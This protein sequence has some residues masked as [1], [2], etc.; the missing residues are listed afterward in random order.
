MNLLKELA[1]V[2]VVVV[3]RAPRL[4]EPARLADTLARRTLRLVEITLTVE[5]ALEAISAIAAS[6]GS[7]AVVGAGTVLDADGARAAIAHGARFLVTPAG[8]DNVLAAGLDAGI[9]VMVGALTPTE[10]LTAW[11]GGASAVKVFPAGIGGP[12]YLRELSGPLP[13]IP[14]VPSGGVGA[15]DAAAFLDAGAAAVSCGSSA[16]PVRA[17]M[18]GDWAEIDGSAAKL[19]RAVSA[20]RAPAS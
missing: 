11:R 6:Q 3:I 10:V 13:E 14:L 15:A 18:A 8:V 20:Y 19:A 17:L 4:D 12:G 7:A 1:L 5:N 9:P 16:V 2:R